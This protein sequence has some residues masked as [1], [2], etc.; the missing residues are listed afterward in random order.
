VLGALVDSAL[1]EV[2]RQM[3]ARRADSRTLEQALTAIFDAHT[4]YFAT[5]PDDLSLLFQGQVLSRLKRS[6]SPELERPFM[7]Y[8]TEIEQ[9]IAAAVPPPAD[10]ARL[11]RLACATV[12]CVSGF[13][14][15][16]VIGMKKEDIAP[17]L[18]ALR[19]AFIA[20]APLLL[21]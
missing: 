21:A 9:Q 19:Q 12:G 5:R 16:A 6:K 15:A 4:Q 20:G 2:I 17:A 10:A 14:S 11:R 13:L 3:H 18:P 7:A 8:L 1:A